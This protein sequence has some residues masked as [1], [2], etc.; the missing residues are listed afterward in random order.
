[1][2]AVERRRRIRMLARENT[3]RHQKREKKRKSTTFEK[4]SADVWLKKKEKNFN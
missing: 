4:F 1:M 2:V 3:S